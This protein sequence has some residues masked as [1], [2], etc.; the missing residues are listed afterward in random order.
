M[1]DKFFRSRQAICSRYANQEKGPPFGPATII[2]LL[3]PWPAL[4]AMLS[5]HQ[6]AEQDGRAVGDRTPE[7]SMMQLLDQVSQEPKSVIS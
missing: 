3:V 7:L 5:Y 1:P 6:G 2:E 4:V